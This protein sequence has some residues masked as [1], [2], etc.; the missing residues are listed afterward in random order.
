MKKIAIF[1]LV[2]FWS[3]PLLAQ[4]FLGTRGL[5]MGE[6]LRGSLLLN[7]AIY[8]NPAA[9]GPTKKYSLEAQTVFN[10]TRDQELGYNISLIDTRGTSIGAGFGYSG[11]K[12]KTEGE[13]SEW[14]H[15][16]NLSLAQPISDLLSVGATSKFALFD[17]E[18]LKGHANAD[19]GVIIFPGP[20]KEY[21]QIG[22]VIHNLA[23]DEKAFPRQIGVGTRINIMKELGFTAD[24]VKPVSETRW[25][26]GVG[27]E[28]VH[29]S[30]LLARAGFHYDSLE[31]PAYSLGVGYF[32]NQV[33]VSYSFRNWVDNKLQT[34]GLSV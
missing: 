22:A 19:F 1:G 2:I 26:F 20:Y 7:D 18:K 13:K 12:I 10:P 15:F 5:A 30:G 11:G 34:H 29:G 6:A 8:F 28:F 4:E 25:I 27:G 17:E 33:G 31:P 24:V 9:M 32:K 23:K 21:F 16:F 3:S 14:R